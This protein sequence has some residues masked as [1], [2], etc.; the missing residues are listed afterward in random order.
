[1]DLWSDISRA[2]IAAGAVDTSSP[3]ATTKVAVDLA[4][5]I[6]G[7][8]LNHGW[9]LQEMDLHH[10]AGFME[11]VLDGK[12][13]SSLVAATCFHWPSIRSPKGYTPVHVAAQKTKN[14][15]S[16]PPGKHHGDEQKELMRRLWH[17]FATLMPEEDGCV[18]AAMWL[19]AEAI[20]EK[21]SQ[22]AVWY[23]IER[24]K[25]NGVLEVVRL[26]KYG[27]SSR[28]RVLKFPRNSTQREQRDRKEQM[29]L[30]QSLEPE[31]PWEP[32]MD[33]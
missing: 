29:D 4:R 22:K 5:T 30:N 17:I 14:R 8:T 27:T 25:S 13:D 26:G 31:Q 19:L 21:T 23:A 24:M 12:G 6:Q 7:L 3:K 10:L 11:R 18:Y 1:M 32:W 33:A 28:Y 9:T 15:K 20:G 2:V 16:Y